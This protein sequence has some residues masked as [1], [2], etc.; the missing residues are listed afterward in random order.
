MTLY[1]WNQNLFRLDYLSD[2]F[3]FLVSL[4]CFLQEVS[5]NYLI[6]K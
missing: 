6:R 2:E 3:T 4:A 1:Y 5:D